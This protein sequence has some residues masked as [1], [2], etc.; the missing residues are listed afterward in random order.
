MLSLAWVRFPAIWRTL[1]FVVCCIWFRM[2]FWSSDLP[3]IPAMIAE[4]A[5]SAKSK[6]WWLSMAMRALWVRAFCSIISAEA[7]RLKRGFDSLSSPCRMVLARPRFWLIVRVRPMPA[8]EARLPIRV[9]FK[10]MPFCM[11]KAVCSPWAAMLWANPAVVLMPRAAVLP[12]AVL[13]VPVIKPMPLEKIE[14]KVRFER[15]WA[16]AAK[17]PA[18]RMPTATETTATM[19]F[20][21]KRSLDKRSA[22]R[23][24]IDQMLRNTHRRSNLDY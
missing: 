12:S 17:V 3:P 23:F 22:S 13:P 6:F 1:E 21:S 4:L 20:F 15:P 11:P 19:T 8:A 9:L 5:S 18:V 24:T 2:E 10:S 16:S 7:E 14:P